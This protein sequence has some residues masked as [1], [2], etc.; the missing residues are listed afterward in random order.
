MYIQFCGANREVTGSCHLLEAGGKKILVDCGMFQGNE[1]SEAKNLDDFPFD[2]REVDVMLLTHAHL[3]HVGRI[4]KLVKDGFSGTI[5]CTKATVPLAQIV[6][7]D[8]ARIMAYNNR[9]FHSPVVYTEEEATISVAQFEGIDYHERVEF[10]PGMFATWKD[11]GHI[12]GS[13]FIE[14]E[15]EGKRIVFSGDIGNTDAPII[16]DTEDLGEVDVLVLESTYGDRLHEERAVARE[17]LH[18]LVKDTCLSGGV[19]MIPAFSIE[20]TQEI[21][22]DLN[23]MLETDT[24]L[25]HF[26]VYLDSPMA[27]A[28]TR[29]FEQFPEYYD[30]EAKAHLDAG[31]NF[32]SFPSL[33]PTYTKEQSMEINSSSKPKMVIAGAGMMNGGRIL[34]HAQRYLPDPNSVLVIVGYQAE[35]SLGRKLYEGT[36]KVTIFND[37]VEVHARVKA[38]GG[39][40]AHADQKKLMDWIATAPQPPK[41]VFCVH[42]EPTAATT[43]A[44]KIRDSFG[45]EA[46]VPEYAEQVDITHI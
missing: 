9:K 27:I 5:F 42:G 26:P 10:L 14:V 41:Q 31:D 19:I 40:S 11:A 38:I 7:E 24:S 8:A 35:G 4:P 20:R 46:Y 22:H 25:P 16:K 30:A 39:M 1:F 15:V 28:V 43:L 34:H 33:I 23:H 3:D 32:L 36:K 21:I 13:A 17:M 2:P 18:K 45:S 6:M 44:H 29:V 12:F 37:P